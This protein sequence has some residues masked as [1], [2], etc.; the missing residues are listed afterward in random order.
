MEVLFALK[1]LQEHEDLIE[2]DIKNYQITVPQQFLP[3]IGIK[4]I[5]PSK[6]GAEFLS[7]CNPLAD[8]GAKVGNPW[9]W[10]PPKTK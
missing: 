4:V 6:L 2:L 8:K 7:A 3:S 9:W 10:S 1:L 5:Y